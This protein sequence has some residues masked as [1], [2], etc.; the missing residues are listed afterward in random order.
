MQASIAP[1]ERSCSPRAS[2]A[3]SARPIDDAATLLVEIAPGVTIKVARGAVG[4]VVSRDEVEEAAVDETP[5]RGADRHHDPHRRRRRGA[6]TWHAPSR[7]GRTLVIFFVGVGVL[8]G[9]SPSPAP[10]SPSSVW[11]SRAAPRITLTATGD[12]SD[13]NLEEARRIIDQRVNGSG[14]AEAEV[15][16]QGGR[17]HRRRDPRDHREPPRDRGPGRAAGAAPVP[18]GRL[19]RRSLRTRARPAALPAGRAPLGAG[20]ARPATTV[21]KTNDDDHRRPRDPTRTSR[22]RPTS[23]APTDPGAPQ[24]EARRCRPQPRRTRSRAAAA[25]DEESDRAVQQA[26][27][28]RERRASSGPMP[29]G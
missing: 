3:P 29:S 27:V 19:R 18:P 7:P 21:G 20:T 6:L 23:P 9:S 28:R 4:T 12:P 17:L 11:T 24:D 26:P 22:A 13:E 16:T 8:S 10:G 1:G 2:S 5:D 15:T 25:P 14:V